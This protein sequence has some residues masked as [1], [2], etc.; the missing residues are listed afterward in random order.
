M[1]DKNIKTLPLFIGGE[2]VQSSSSE[3]KELLDPSTNEVLAYV[4][5]AGKAEIDQAVQLAK[6]AFKEWREVPVPERARLFFKYQKALKDSQEGIARILA[7]EKTAKLLKTP[8]G[9]FGGGLRLWSKPA[10]PQLL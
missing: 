2:F 9:M 5:Y 6:K 3:R 8:K 10:M 7:E 1:K 4:P